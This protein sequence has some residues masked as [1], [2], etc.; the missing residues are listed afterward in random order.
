MSD[1]STRIVRWAKRNMP[2]REEL[3]HNRWVRPFARR[4]ELWRFT[5]RSV[6]RGVAVGL[7]VGIFAL[8]P[9]I[10]IV[11]AALLCVPCRGNIPLAALMTFLS[12]PATTPLI[13]AGSIWLGNK[14]GFHADV[15]TFYALYESG[16]GMRQWG[17]W[18]LSDAAP[19][20]LLGLFIVSTISASIGYL[21]AAFAW[22]ARI[23]R[24][25]RAAQQRL[26]RDRQG[27]G[28]RQP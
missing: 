13:L 11:G 9:G 12:N 8:I 5:R 17:G 26:L 6:P 18:L 20:M 21:V 19:A 28:Q 2:R 10:Q 7:L 24:R 25:R 1:L 23:R 27:Q 3:E 15:D 22:N 14:L 16:A 4:P